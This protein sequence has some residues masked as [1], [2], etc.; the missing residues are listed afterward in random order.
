MDKSKL[1]SPPQYCEYANGQCDQVFDDVQPNNG[2]FLYPS[3]PPQIAATIENAV[4]MLPASG[5]KGW[6]TWK[7]LHTAGQII[8]CTICKAMR[9][10]DQA[11]ADVTTLNFNLL[12]EIGFL[13]GLELPVIP[14]RDASYLQDEAAFD[15]LGML[16]TIGYTN[17]QNSKEL[18]KSLLRRIPVNPIPTPS[19]DIN[20]ETP[21]YVLKGPLETEGEVV[22]F[23]ILKKSVL[24][25]RTFDILETPRLSLHTARKQVVSALGVIAHLLDPNRKGATVHNARC[26]LVAGIG[27]ACGKTVLMLQEGNVSQPIDYREVVK[28]YTK[29]N[30]IPKLMDPTI[31]QVLG[32]LQTKRSRDFKAP[33]GLLEKIDLGDVAAE[34]EIFTLNSYFVKTGQYH[35]AKQGYARLVIG[36]KG[37]G[38]TAI[39]YAVRNSIGY[40]RNRTILDLK[41]EGHQF[42]KLRETI[43]T[44]LSPGLQEHTMAAFWNSILLSEIAHKVTQEEYSWAQRDPDRWKKFQAVMEL[45]ERT[46]YAEKGDFSERLL[47]QVDRLV[48]R[49]HNSKGT[50]SSRS[51]TE[52]LYSGDIHDLNDAVSRYLDEKEE[53]WILIDNIDKGWPIHGALR[54]DILIIRTLLEATRKL[55]RQLERNAIDFHCLVFL[56]NDIYEHLVLETPDKGKDTAITLDWSDKEFFKE[57]FRRRVT[58][59]GELAGSFDEVWE[60]ILEPN[61]GTR[62]SFSYI[63]ERTLLRP[64]DFLNFVLRAIEIAINRGHNSVLQDDILRA[65]ESYSEDVLKTIAFELKDVYLNVPDFLY[66][67][68]G[69]KN[70]LSK[71]EVLSLLAE[72]GIEE[73]DLEST[74]NLL[75]WFGFLGVQKSDVND[76]RYSYQMQ[77]DM[78]KLIQ[79]IKRGSAYF[80]IHPAFRSA[81]ECE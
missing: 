27:M 50:P 21:L 38:K 58:A 37:S 54:E 12:F 78:A 34:N 80:V 7:D 6:L 79:P 65:E 22:L 25:F 18:S 4:K 68:P 3:D 26:A 14:I 51:I 32:R 42:T 72:T 35:Q 73:K 61:V 1:Q 23:S 20:F 48:E 57:I 24:R 15:Q 16:D 31:L 19:A 40:S 10:S 53:V 64:R 28:S 30:Q 8:Y 63:V 77:Y 56:R 39:F 36:R 2:L 49:Y 29:P 46:G 5:Q 69:C 47:H 67:F 9:F 59:S 41:P 81:L 11:V 75:C 76:V 43:L 45:Y 66:T 71:Q 44:K 13:L 60:T 62:D 33:E 70:R 55:Q 74:I 52:L 17:F